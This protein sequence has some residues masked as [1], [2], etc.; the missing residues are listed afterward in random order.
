MISTGLGEIFQYTLHS[1][2]HNLTELRTLQD[3]EIAPRLRVIPGVN[4]VNSFGGMVRQVHVLIDP[5]KLLKYDLTLKE[6]VQ[7]VTASNANAGGSFILKDWEQENIRCAGLLG[8]MQDVRDVVLLS[9][10]GTPVYV[11]DVATVTEGHAIRLGA[12]SRDGKGEVVAGTVIMLKGENSKEVVDR[13]KAALPAIRS[14]YP[15]H[16]FLHFQCHLQYPL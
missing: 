5:D 9:D 13:V 12:V 16:L 3:W 15:L 10:S 11:S 1:D 14:S 4:E 6:V 7:S 8:S 2:R